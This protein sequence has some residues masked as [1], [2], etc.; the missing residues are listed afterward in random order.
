MKRQSYLTIVALIAALVLSQVNTAFAQG[1]SNQAFQ[2]VKQVQENITPRLLNMAN[3]EATAIGVNENNEYIIHI[4]TSAPGVVGLPRNINGIPVQIEVTDPFYALGYKPP[5]RASKV[6][7][8]L[9]KVPP[10]APSDLTATAAGPYQINL[11]WSDNS[12]NET[13]FIIE[14]WDNYGGYI[15]IEVGANVTS[16]SD[17]GLTPGTEYHYQVYA[18]N[19][20]GD[21]D[22][23][24]P[25][26]ATTDPLS[27]PVPDAPSDLSAE[28]I[29]STQISLT[30]IDNSDN[31]TGFGAYYSSGGPDGPWVYLGTRPENATM[32][33]VPPILE[34]DT[35]YWFRIYAFND[36]GESDYSNT[37]SATTYPPSTTAPDAPSD[38]AAT[39]ISSSQI[40]LSWADNS[41]DELG[42]Y[43][44]A[45]RIYTDWYLLGYVGPNVTVVTVNNLYPDTEYGFMVSAYN[46]YDESE[47]IGPVY[48]TTYPLPEDDPR[49]RFDYPIPI[50]VSTGHFDITAGT[51][52]CRVK[53]TEGNIYALSNNHVYANS[54]Q[55]SINDEIFQPGPADGG[56][57]D[58]TIGELYAYVP[59]DFSP[60]AKNFVDAA[61]ALIYD[62]PD[63]E[64]DYELNNTTLTGYTPSSVTKKATVNLDVKK[65][66]RTTRETHGTVFMLNWKGKIYYGSSVAYFTSQIYITSEDTF[67]SGGDSGSL[68]VTD[69]NNNYP[70]ALLFAGNSSG[71]IA[72]PIDDVLTQLSLVLTNGQYSDELA[73][74]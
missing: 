17:T 50:G 20:Y 10:T 36:F 11:S 35:T 32:G 63:Y 1:R 34:P 12:E 54:N 46:D 16:Y 2:R 37:A 45:K 58:D 48:A 27:G 44:Y 8:G 28:P 23:S 6:P 60:G 24:N 31:E 33:V 39:P 43:V 7:P 9:N 51:I 72:C 18:Y 71:T 69:D 40:K 62:D 29:S 5:V 13:G 70:V 25:D 59:L 53:D 21:S 65:Y 22:Y 68:I 19:K 3:I 49:G 47:C 14:S 38:L 30:W 41:T 52:G 15:E 56:I 57:W 26:S 55:A 64:D 74:E 67:S 42:F 66:G 73:I 61:I 4:F